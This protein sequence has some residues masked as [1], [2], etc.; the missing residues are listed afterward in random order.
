MIQLIVRQLFVDIDPVTD[1]QDE[2]I[3][4]FVDNVKKEEHFPIIVLDDAN[5]LA[6]EVRE[7]LAKEFGWFDKIDKRVNDKRLTPRIVIIATKY[8]E[9]FKGRDQGI[10]FQPFEIE[11]FADHRN[12]K[13]TYEYLLQQA[14]NRYSNQK[15][16]EKSPIPDRWINELF[17]LAGGHP[18]AIVEILNYVGR[19]THYSQENCFESQKSKIHTEILQRLL[20]QQFRSK[21]SEEE[22]KSLKYIWIFRYTGRSLFRELL[23]RIADNPNWQ[24]FN[25]IVHDSDRKGGEKPGSLRDRVITSDNFIMQGRN[26]QHRFFDYQLSPIWRKIGNTMLLFEDENQYKSLHSDAQEF[27]YYL[28]TNPKNA[29]K[30]ALQI[31]SFIE[32]LY[33]MAELYSPHQIAEDNDSCQEQL[34]PQAKDRLSEFITTAKLN[35]DFDNSFHFG[36]LKDL[37]E[38]D[39]ELR[40][41]LNQQGASDT[42]KQLLS[43][44]EQQIE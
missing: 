30:F 33:H 15:L 39:R 36:H 34:A 18:E 31:S 4:R 44:I 20:M 6:P 19:T 42:D 7:E 22:I 10:K 14:V 9:E 23:N 3:D 38:K 40:R 5:S 32:Y 2:L 25:A 26:E 37:L 35:P 24:E 29:K 12:D 17:D 27:Y 28:F 43:L 11:M 21:F 16:A 8:L 1:D 13:K 41:L